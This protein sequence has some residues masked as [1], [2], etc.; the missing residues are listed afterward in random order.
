MT[1]ISQI[2]SNINT[3]KDIKCSYNEQKNINSITLHSNNIKVIEQGI[4]HKFI[5]LT[6]LDLSSNQIEKIQGLEKLYNLK[7]L[8]LS[9]NKIK[10]IE[11]LSELRAL[12]KLLLAYNNIKTLEGFV[13]LHG[14]HYS[15]FI[16]DIRGNNIENI[17]EIKY[18]AGCPVIINIFYNIV[19]PF[20]QKLKYSYRDNIKLLVPQLESIDEMDF[21]GNELEINDI[22][23]SN[24]N[25]YKSFLKSMNENESY[26]F[27]NKLDP[28][29]THF[30]I[31]NKL[32][33]DLKI[34][35]IDQRVKYIEQAIQDISENKINNE[36][37]E[38]KRNKEIITQDNLKKAFEQVL[39]SFCNIRDNE[40]N[41]NLD[42]GTKD[43]K[44]DDS[45]NLINNKNDLNNISNSKLISI[46]SQIS[47]IMK[48][49]I[50]NKNNEDKLNSDNGKLDDKKIDRQNDIL[51]I[52]DLKNSFSLINNSEI[53]S[54][55]NNE[56]LVKLEK[57]PRKKNI[58]NNVTKKKKNDIYNKKNDIIS[59]ISKN[60]EIQR[61][62]K[63]LIDEN[64]MDS[65]EKSNSTIN[66][67]DN[68]R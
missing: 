65:S 32:E 42:K 40:E 10:I 29:N 6:I 21:Y 13:Q 47:E 64:D 3:I 53:D 19:N 15:L 41:E 5:N 57:T 7:I 17:E 48:L 26:R 16:L 52:N 43:Q 60:Y 33:D 36:N 54:N 58:I 18:L 55:K 51:L 2:Y 34:N 46:E 8:N 66:T 39:N 24:I 12:S 1:E 4:L 68:N 35:N 25:S 61:I 50:S 63:D 20:C 22:G 23:N 9:N 31:N 44:S 59:N 37:N 62:K 28:V 38:N 30:S 11:G 67:K 27:N 45:D 14:I 56:I 49:L